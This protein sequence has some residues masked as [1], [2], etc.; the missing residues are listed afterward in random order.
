MRPGERDPG[1]PA[2]VDRHTRQLCHIVT[3][4]ER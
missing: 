4:R 3:E 1:D 2:L